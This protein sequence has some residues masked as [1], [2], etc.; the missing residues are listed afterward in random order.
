LL[1]VN[2]RAG[3]GQEG[4]LAIDAVL[5][6]EVARCALEG[7]REARLVMDAEVEPLVIRAEAEVP[8][9]VL[10]IR[11]IEEIDG[12]AVIELEVV[13]LDLQVAAAAFQIL[14]EA[15]IGGLDD[16]GHR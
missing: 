7:V 9:A 15:V 12:E 14:V 3:L 2:A 1:E 8:L 6:R 4:D 13:M 5:Q 11:P 10:D 16:I